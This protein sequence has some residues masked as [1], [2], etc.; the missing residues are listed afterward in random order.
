MMRHRSSPTGVCSTR[1]AR[2][3]TKFSERVESVMQ[4]PG[5]GALM[6]IQ[7]ANK[8][9]LNSRPRCHVFLG[10]SL[11]AITANARPIGWFGWSRLIRSL[12]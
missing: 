7:R 1:S 3:L 12:S 5:H 2:P 10:H 9:G 8:R 6:H 11:V 4:L